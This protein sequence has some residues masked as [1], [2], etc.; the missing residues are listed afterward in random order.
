MRVEIDHAVGEDPSRGEIVVYG[1]NVM[2][3]YHRRPEENAKA[4]MPDGGFRTGDLGYMD[5]DGYL[6]VTGRIKEQYKLENGKY[7]MPSPLEEELK[8]SP[9]V[10]NVMIYGDGRPFNVAIVAPNEA[11]IREWA[12]RQELTLEKDITR[13]ARVHELIE[14]ELELHSRGFKPFERPLAFA[15]VPEDFTTQNGMLTPT[16]KLR[17]RDVVTRHTALLE[18]LYA[19]KAPPARRDDAL[20]GRT[21]P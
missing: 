5:A 12:V 21:L 2:M 18:R 13:D 1:P 17:R 11:A 4:L 16:L 14:G 3:G 19:E 10:A 7:V 20:T 6:F 9:F 8:L 15:L